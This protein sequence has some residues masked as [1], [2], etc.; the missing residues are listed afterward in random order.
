MLLIEH[1][2]TILNMAYS[3]IAFE[4]VVMHVL[5]QIDAFALEACAV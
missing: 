3:V 5:C 2:R 1:L 4:P